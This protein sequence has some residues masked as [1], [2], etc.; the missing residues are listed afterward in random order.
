MVDLLEFD[1]WFSYGHHRSKF[2]GN[3]IYYFVLQNWKYRKKM[4]GD[5]VF[6]CRDFS[7]SSRN[8]GLQNYVL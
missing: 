4:S 6:N 5:I 8:R 2:P 1:S 7:R 3:G